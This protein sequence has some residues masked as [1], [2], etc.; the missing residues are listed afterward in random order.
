M[1]TCPVCAYNRLELPPAN[2]SICACCGT[3]FGYDD[4]SL[5]H[6]ELT[7][8]WVERNCPW[9]DI[10]EPKPVGWNGYAQLINGGLARAVPAELT[11]SN[12][13]SKI[14]NS[15]RKTIWKLEW[16]NEHPQFTLELRAA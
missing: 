8:R 16:G 2:F 13:R 3:E 14:E 10:D 6:Y 9:F 15:G 1:Y 12:N 5:S 11:A 7:K 4:R